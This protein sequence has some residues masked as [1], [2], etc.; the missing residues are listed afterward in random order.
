MEKKWF[1]G[2]EVGQEMSAPPPKKNPGS[3]PGTQESFVRGSS[4]TKSNPFSFFIPLLTK[5]VP[6][7]NTFYR[8]RVPLSHTFTVVLK[9]TSVMKPLPFDRQDKTR[10]DNVLFGVL[11]SPMYIDFI[12][13]I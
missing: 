13:I 2:V 9:L 3:A 12:Q 5:K 8:Q 4:S 11:Y 6:L 10:Q 7:S 1:I